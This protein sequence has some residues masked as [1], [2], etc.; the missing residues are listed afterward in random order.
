MFNSPLRIVGSA[1]TLGLLLCCAAPRLRAQAPAGSNPAPDS[2]FQTYAQSAA[3]ARDAGRPDEAVRNYQAALKIDPKWQ[4]GWWNLG[5]LL[6]EHDQYAD[7][8]PPFQTLTQLAPQASPGWTFLGLCEFETK[9]YT[10]ALDHLSQGEEL[11]GVD[12]PEIARVAKYHLALLLIC[13]GDF[14]RAKFALASLASAGQSSPQVKFALGL[15]LLRVPLLPSE[16]DP[17]KEAL[18]QD[19]GAIAVAA[20]SAGEVAAFEAT[21]AKF[22]DAPYL[23]YAFG[24]TLE[25]NT[26]SADALAQFRREAEISPQSALPQMGI[27][28]TARQLGRTEEALQAAHEAVRLAPDSRAAHEWLAQCVGDTGDQPATSA[29]LALA[30]Q[31]GPDK[32]SIEQRIVAWYG[33]N[34]ATR[35]AS[36]ESAA[37]GDELF[38]AAMR[39]FS[40]NQFPETISALKT[41]LQPNANSGTGWAVLG[42]SEFALRDYDNALI[43]LQRGEQLGMSGGAENVA[44]AKYRLGILLNR[45]GQ[46][47][48]AEQL[49]MS[50]TA[51]QPLANEIKFALG[52]ALLHIAAFPEEAPSSQH[53]LI[54][55]AG[56]IAALLRDSKYDL[57]FSRLEE[58]LKKYPTAPFL[59]YTYGTALASLSQFDEAAKQFREELPLS[60]ESELPYLGIASLELK[61]HRAAD[62]LEPAQQAVRLASRNATARYLLGRSYLETGKATEAIAELQ[63]AS[64]ITPGSPEVHF[65]LAKAYAKANQPAK[66]EEERAIFVQLNARAEQQRGQQGNQSYGAHDAA[67]AAISSVDRPAIENPKPE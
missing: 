57:A 60:R 46:F 35:R 33:T 52:M 12:D 15:A 38:A 13:T 64:A 32:P 34:V 22:P 19:A 49:L 43:H 63:Q 25:R 56:D 5:T 45:S 24:E 9:D 17:S 55:S 50:A 59:H 27:V 8:I 37:G 39:D 47:S 66:A 53:A 41:W 28:R 4:E 16:I 58:L 65:S 31:V 26:R 23:H 40:A 42:L 7:A 61:R 18:V 11:G 6:Y 54:E 10:N 30:A 3:A 51:P 14:D 48:A 44:L 29:E 20:I 67:N 2:T 21:I 36:P 62:A 1:I